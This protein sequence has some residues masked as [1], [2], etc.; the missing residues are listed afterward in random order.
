MDEALEVIRHK[1]W[2]RQSGLKL[3]AVFQ[4]ILFLILKALRVFHISVG[5]FFVTLV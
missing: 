5:M 2:D 3:I 4:A 1:V